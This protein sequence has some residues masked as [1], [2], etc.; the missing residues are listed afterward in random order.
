MGKNKQKNIEKK[1]AEFILTARPIDDP[2]YNN[3]N[4]P[5]NVLLYVPKE[6]DDDKTQHTLDNIPESIRG[7]TF[8]DE[9]QG[10]LLRQKLGITEEE[11]NKEK[12]TKNLNESIPDLL[13]ENNDIDLSN[14][15][16]IINTNIKKEK[17]KEN[18]KEDKKEEK[19]IQFKPNKKVT[20][21]PVSTLT[22]KELLEGN[23]DKLLDIDDKT[24][25]LLIK[26]SKLKIDANL[27]EYN[28][29]GLKKGINPEILEYVTD[30]KF[31]EGLDIFIPAP[32]FIESLQQNR[33]DCDIDPNEMNP[34]YKEVYD[35]LNSEG[36]ENDGGLE[37]DFILLANEGKLPIDLLDNCED[38]K[39]E[40]V[41][42][43]TN[44]KVNVEP[45][46][47]YITKEE[48]EFLD[49]QFSKTYDEYYKDERKINNG[50]EEEE[51]EE[52]EDFEEE[53]LQDK[54][55]SKDLKKKE[56]DDA[57]N[58]LLPKT[59]RLDKK[60]QESEEE[61]EEL[62][63][64]EEF[65]DFDENLLD[66]EHI[67]KLTE[68]ENESD[69]KYSDKIIIQNKKKNLVEKPF[70]KKKKSPIVKEVKKDEETIEELETYL[71]S[72]EVV[73]MDLKIATNSVAQIEKKEEINKNKKDVE[74]DEAY[75]VNYAKKYL[76]ITSVGGT[77][78][79]MPKVVAIE[80]DLKKYEKKLRK[81]EKVR[82]E[83]ENKEKEEK[84]EENKNKNLEND[85]D[86]LNIGKFSHLESGLTKKEDN[87]LRKKLLKDEK[88]EKRILKKE[89]KVAFKVNLFLINSN[90][91]FFRMKK[92][93][94]QNKLLLR[95]Q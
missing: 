59:K 90:F 89:I 60:S 87:K 70:V 10:K 25:D 15:E 63:E 53:V 12:N 93:N 38:D 16:E 73:E 64:E 28:E 95:I 44:K 47:K 82:K 41:L 20:E 22:L 8:D 77:F 50:V 88:K 62:E 51:F 92:I 37:D 75:I 79:N 1:T 84:E 46:Y 5:Q 71:F 33:V 3:P 39:D 61:N 32:N 34:D 43:E 58:E 78:G 74:E 76:D 86:D 13:S 21:T 7:T 94:K 45:S 56:F 4:V 24:L 26:K 23:K 85:K 42:V 6:N 18:N 68:A 2:D 57:I 27:V 17:K 81:I 72:K 80:G 19:K 36:E 67:R 30:K 11:F 83:K 65:E 48:K 31:R 91:Y 69:I 35:A 52:Y 54:K 49:K 40:I 29:Y 66:D 9:I 55:I 14:D